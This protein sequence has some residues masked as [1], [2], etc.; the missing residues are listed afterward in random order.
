MGGTLMDAMES[1]SAALAQVRFHRRD[2]TQCS[3]ARVVQPVVASAFSGRLPIL[4][5]AP[6][7]NPPHPLVQAGVRGHAPP[8]GCACSCSW[9]AQQES[10]TVS[11]HGA[12]MS[13]KAPEGMTLPMVHVECMQR[14]KCTHK[15]TTASQ[16]DSPGWLG[17]TQWQR[18]R[19]Q[20]S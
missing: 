15:H 14:D 12:C 8:E 10:L 16:I 2:A 6:S 13:S 4:S 17:C 3:Q 9:V 5:H 20:A 1:A 18:Q 7:P 19:P 11:G